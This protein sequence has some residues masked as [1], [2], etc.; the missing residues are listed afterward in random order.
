M[1]NPIQTVTRQDA[2]EPRSV[3]ERQAHVVALLDELLAADLPPLEWI[4]SNVRPDRLSG[5]VSTFER[6]RAEVLEDL[7][8]WANY[9]GRPITETPRLDGDVTV[10]V[11]EVRDGITVDIWS[12]V[13]VADEPPAAT[14]RPAA[15]EAL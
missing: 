12:L 3:R 14:S 11:T 4:V 7:E 10:M 13:D 6:S 5:L 9:L 8:E 2:A 1:T 15:G